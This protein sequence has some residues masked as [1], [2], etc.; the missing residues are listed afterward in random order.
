MAKLCNMFKI[1]FY[2]H[3][4]WKVQGSIS[5]PPIHSLC[6][7]HLKISLQ[8]IHPLPSDTTGKVCTHSFW[9]FFS[10]SSIIW[11]PSRERERE[12]ERDS[13]HVSHCRIS[14]K[15]WSFVVILFKLFFILEKCIIPK[16]L[17]KRWIS[18][19]RCHG[20]K[21]VL[22]KIERKLERAKI[23]SNIILFPKENTGLPRKLVKKHKN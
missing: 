21:L 12:S 19:G 11:L 23:S 13:C 10:H 14:G 4:T 18:P 6:G 8:A 3:C 5:Y 7:R 20:G 2:A 1:L 15:V 9:I 22:N 17:V 16:G